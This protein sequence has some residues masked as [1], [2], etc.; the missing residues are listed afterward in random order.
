MTS[1]V[2]I[3]HGYEADGRMV[4][5]LDDTALPEILVEKYTYETERTTL[6]EIYRDNQAVDGTE[7]NI[8]HEA[9]SLSI[10]DIIGFRSGV[11]DGLSIGVPVWR[12]PETHTAV[13]TYGFVGLTADEF[14]GIPKVTQADIKDRRD[15]LNRRYAER[16]YHG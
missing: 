14:D 3:Y 12:T 2:T 1:T 11:K 15:A 5:G 7:Q 4:S 13:V 10:G 16:A 6:D 8:K 9:R